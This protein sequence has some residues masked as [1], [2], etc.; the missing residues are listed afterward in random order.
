MYSNFNIF[1]ID[2]SKL[3]LVNPPYTKVLYKFQTC[4]DSVIT[5]DFEDFKRIINSLE[6]MNSKSFHDRN[7]LHLA[8]IFQHLNMI[9][10]LL[11]KNIAVNDKDL[12]GF[13][14]L[15]YC[16]NEEIASLLKSKGAKASGLEMDIEIDET[17]KILNQDH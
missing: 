3:N 17:H 13:T 9:N 14:P 12:Y 7:L 10:Y 15:D 16:K 11:D 4:I 5:G 2:Q 6:N 8:V 1:Q